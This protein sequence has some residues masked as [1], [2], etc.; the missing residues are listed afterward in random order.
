[1]QILTSLIHVTVNANP[2]ISQN[3]DNSYALPVPGCLPEDEIYVRI[4]KI[5]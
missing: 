1:M 5:L 2:P 4:L 3:N